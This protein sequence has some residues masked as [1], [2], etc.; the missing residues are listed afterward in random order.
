EGHPR[1]LLEGVSKP[2]LRGGVAARPA[3]IAGGGRSPGALRRL[4]GPARPA[5]EWLATLGGL[6]RGG[7]SPPD[8]HLPRTRE[9]SSAGGKRPRSEEGRG[10]DLRAVGMGTILHRGGPRVGRSLA[11]A[12]VRARLR[13]SGPIDGGVRGRLPPAGRLPRPVPA[14]T[15][16]RH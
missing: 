10:I 3:G 13:G 4:P 8:G 6:L 7:T 5:S 16:D 15:S 14:R 12:I 9:D 11:P 2:F 1:V